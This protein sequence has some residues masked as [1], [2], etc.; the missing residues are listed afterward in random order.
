M[1][2][3][4]VYF[5]IEAGYRWGEGMDDI[6][7]AAFY[8]EVKTLFESA[9]WCVVSHEHNG[10]CPVV[11]KDLSSLY[12]HPMEIS[13][14]IAIN[15]IDEV[16]GLLGNG[17]TFNHYNTDEYDTIIEM[18]DDEYRAYLD[19]N[20]KAIRRD[21]IDAFKTKRSNLYISQSNANAIF[22]AVC[23]KWHIH[24]IQS[25]RNWR[26]ANIIE[27]ELIYRL[28]QELLEE[29]HI[30]EGAIKS[31]TGYRTAKNAA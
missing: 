10:S 9:G 13:G 31:G 1:D 2:Y 30:V 7:K 8:T 22:N 5:R 17:L 15:L 11:Q 27:A 24:R 16:K 26:D 19:G 4:N 23:R 25:G 14:V 28:F 21:I 12:C 18:S 20:R 29:E 3:K 6:K